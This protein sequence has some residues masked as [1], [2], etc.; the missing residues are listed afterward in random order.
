[1]SVMSAIK[2]FHGYVKVE[3][4]GYAPERFL[5]LCSNHNILL[6][7]L[8]PIKDGYI[9]Y[10]SI[11][12]FRLLKPILKK[13]GTKVKILE[14][15]GTPFAMYRYRK[16]KI[17]VFGILLCF[18]LLYYLSGFVWNIEIRGNSHL[19]EETLLEFL[20]QE[21]AGFGSP[22]S[23]IDCATLEE[24][25]RSCYDEVI[26]ASVKIYGTKMTVDM[27]ESL[28]YDTSAQNDDSGAW[29]IIAEKD[30]IITEMVTRSGTPMVAVGTVVQAGDVLVS[31]RSEIVNDNGEV[32]DYLYCKADADVVALV[33]EEYYEEISAK[34]EE[35]VKTGDYV[36]DYGILLG[37]VLLENPFLKVEY[38]N[39]DVLQNQY[40]LHFTDNFY[41]PVSFI[42]Y[43]Y[44]EYEVTEKE[45]SMQEAKKVAGEDFL[46][47]LSN[48]EEKG[49]QISEK[50]VMIEK[51]NQKYV[52]RGTIKAYESVVSY[53]PTEILEITSE[54]RQQTDES[55]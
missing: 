19:S 13:T 33:E 4:T 35:K 28:L 26:W 3:L 23:D 12:G 41:L 2:F 42:E 21:N 20:E 15:R 11:T 14:K 34:Y 7:E 24:A 45:Y 55:D 18:G 32:V 51:V 10:V 1:M 36:T 37:N 44:E 40:Q 53:Q 25:L 27:Q 5:N 54:E 49:I 6:W 22:I 48:L 52:V 38:E 16:R 9:F 47:Y 50:N 30:G 17:F 29:D 43:I 39:Y 46:Q 31:G 8:V